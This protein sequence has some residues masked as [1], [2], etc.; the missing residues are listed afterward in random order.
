MSF[1]GLIK[2]ILAASFWAFRRQLPEGLLFAGKFNTK[3]RHDAETTTL[4][5]RAA[6]I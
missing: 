1:D 2:S 4:H 5:A 6:K 3:F